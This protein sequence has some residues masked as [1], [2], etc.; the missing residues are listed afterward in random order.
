MLSSV[1]VFVFSFWLKLAFTEEP[2][3][4]AGYWELSDSATVS[5]LLSEEAIGDLISDAA[6]SS[7]EQLNF[8]R[9]AISSLLSPCL[10]PPCFALLRS[11]LFPLF[12]AEMV[13]VNLGLWNGEARGTDG[14]GFVAGVVNGFVTVEVDGGLR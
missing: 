6:F 4:F 8:G 13:N 5:L 7:V 11:A 12:A 3:I 1:D 10:F 14:A 2:S 9:I